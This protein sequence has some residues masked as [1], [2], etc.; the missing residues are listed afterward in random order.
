MKSFVM[1]LIVMG[2][3]FPSYSQ[4][5][6]EEGK[7]ESLKM[8]ELPEIVIKRAGKDFSIYLPDKNIDKNVRQMEEKFISYDL[9][10]DYEGYENYLV[11]MELPK[12]T[13]SATYNSEG[14]LIDVVENYENV[15]LPAK[16]IYSVYKAY[17]DW[18]IVKDKF[19]F[20][21]K[22]GD[23]IKKEYNLKIKKDKKTKNLTVNPEGTIL[24]DCCD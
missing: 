17:P 13:L 18:K 3:F 23:V 24:K 2:L 1:L 8:E 15:R 22:D 16:V 9:G 14:K 4:V 20:T 12:S 6:K 7:D 5:K 21:Q 11:V 19:L 10:K